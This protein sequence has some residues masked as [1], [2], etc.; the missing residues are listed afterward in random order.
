VSNK[1]RKNQ[2]IFFF[3]SATKNGFFLILERLDRGLLLNLTAKYL[4]VFT[5]LFSQD[6]ICT[7]FCKKTVL[8]SQKMSGTL[9]Y[10]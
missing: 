7:F 2:K 3:F 5:V 9:T 6:A 4:T 10:F 8:G 1:V